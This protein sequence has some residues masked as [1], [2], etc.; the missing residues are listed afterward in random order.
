LRKVPREKRRIER[1]KRARAGAKGARVKEEN[2]VDVVVGV[3]G[4]SARGWPLHSDWD[5][6]HLS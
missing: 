3:G 5:E 2:S 4:S 6:Y 1:R